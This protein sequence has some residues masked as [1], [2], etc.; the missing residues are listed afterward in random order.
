MACE[1]TTVAPHPSLRIHGEIYSR[2]PMGD[3]NLWMLQSFII[4]Y[5]Y[6]SMYFKSP[7]YL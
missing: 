5:T 7:D 4:T 2:N 1:E 6:P 3:Q